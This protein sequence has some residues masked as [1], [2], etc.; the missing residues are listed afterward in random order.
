MKLK[1]LILG[2][3]G[4]IGSTIFRVFA[5][6]TDWQVTGTI[7]SKRCKVHSSGS[8]LF[9]V[10]LNNSDQITRLFLKVKPDVVV[11]CVGLT[12]HLPE[13]KDPIPS[14]TLNALLPHRLAEQCTISGSRLIHVSTDCVFSGE[15]GNY[16][17]EDIPDANDLYGKSKA[18]GEVV[19]E[20]VLTIRTSTIG[21]EYGTK[22]GLLEWFLAQKEC[23]GFKHA[24]FSG[25]TTIELAHVIRDF[26]IPGTSISGLYHIGAAAIDKLS[27]LRLIAKI[28]NREINIIPDEVFRID[29]S[30]NVS[31]FK[32]LTG[33]QAPAWPELIEVMYQD[34]LIGQKLYV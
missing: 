14:L 1:V 28:Y 11:N 3:S 21:H 30:L 31:C 26:I 13:G 24:I 7:R 33:Y 18:L 16:V 29:R 6:S 23:N 5:Q 32:N 9:G 10:D 34:Y 22:F 15:K 17:E 27:L 25:L 2:S 4:M 20:N 19:S 12:K 8:I